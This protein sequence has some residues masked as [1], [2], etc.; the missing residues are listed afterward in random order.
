MNDAKFNMAT[1]FRVAENAGLSP[2]SVLLTLSLN[3]FMFK[4]VHT[5]MILLFFLQ[6]T[7]ALNFTQK[8]IFTL[9]TI[10]LFTTWQDVEVIYRLTWNRTLEINFF[11]NQSP[12]QFTMENLKLRME[13]LFE[14]VKL[15]GEKCVSINEA[16]YSKK[17]INSFLA[18]R[19]HST[20]E[21]TPTDFNP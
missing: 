5:L 17:F 9:K 7:L 6:Q 12:V 15:L 10:T 18:M 2:V 1:S 3:C 13:N 11:S 16:N 21:S 19:T 14:G 8:Q 4:I 20:R